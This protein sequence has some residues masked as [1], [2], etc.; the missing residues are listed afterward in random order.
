MAEASQTFSSASA[1]ASVQVYGS[2][3]GTFESMTSKVAEQADSAA[4]AASTN[5]ESLLSAASEQVYGKP[6]PVYESIY[7]QAGDYA[8]QAT[9]GVAAQY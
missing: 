4:S 7:S 6:T 9:Q 5:W 2:E 1:A 8:S 3:T